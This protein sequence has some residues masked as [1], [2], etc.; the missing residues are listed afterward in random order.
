MSVDTIQDGESAASTA[1]VGDVILKITPA[2]MSTVLEIRATEENP[3]GLALRV[4]ITGKKGVE[5]SYDLSFD[6]IDSLTDGYATYTVGPLAVAIPDESVDNL[7]GAELDLPKAGGQGGLV[8]RNPNRSDPMAGIDIDLTGDIPN[9]VNQL[10][11][12]AINP[13]LASHGG[14]ANLVGVDEKNNV[15]VYMGGGC[16]GCSASAMTLKMGIQR[17]IKEHIPEVLEVIDA[18]DHTQGDNPYYS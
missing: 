1:T 4:E 14:Y 8:I 10:L 11:E 18:T 7:R 16:Q 17:S 12:H 2:A 15:Y 5:F 6:D 3:E 13:A 9:K